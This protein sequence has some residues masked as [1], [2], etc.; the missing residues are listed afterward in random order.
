MAIVISAVNQKGGVAKTTTVINLGGALGERGRRVLLVDLDP[1]AHLSLGCG[2]EISPEDPSAYHFLFDEDLRFDDVVKRDVFPGVDLIPSDINLSA[3]DIQLINAFNREKV[4][5]TKLEEHKESYDYIIIDNTPSLSILVIN[6]LTAADYLVIPV[7]CTFWALRG[8]KQLLAI[9]NRIKKH[10]LNESLKI[11]GVLVTMYDPRTNISKDVIDRLEESFKDELFK[12][13][14]S[15]TIKLDYAAVSMESILTYDPS[16][17][18]SKQYRDLAEEVE[19]R[20][21][22]IH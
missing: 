12:T 4:L 16:S 9:I 7:Q 3:A 15:K 6:S 14:I 2:V 8:M 21:S 22:Q 13:K 10:K 11:L 18:V 20:V 19:R 1:Q 5:S 17:N